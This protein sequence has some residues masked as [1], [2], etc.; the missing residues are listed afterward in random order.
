MSERATEI[1][2]AR[3]NNL[4]NI[5]CRFPHGRLT[6]ITGVSG[7]GKSSLAFDTLYAE[8]QRRFIESMSTYARQFLEK[9]R[10]PDVDSIRNIQPAIAIE[11]KNAVKNAR[12][13]VGSATEILDYLR[14]L[15]A[16]IG[17]TICPDCRVPVERDTTDRVAGALLGAGEGARF[18]LLAPV[19]I[20]KASSFGPIVREMQAGGFSRVWT[21]DGLKG[22]EE[23]SAS[24]RD[25]AGAL[26]IVI[27]RLAVREEERARLA[28]S[29]DLAFQIG[30]G[31]AAAIGA[32]G[33]WRRFHRGF[34]CSTCERT[35]REPEPQL[36]S[37]QSPLGAC[38]HCQGYG[39]VIGVDWDKVIP[40]RA[41]SIAER[42]IAAW[43]TPSNEIL[44]DHLEKTTSRSELPRKTPIQD[45]SPGEYRVL[46][47]GNGEFCGIQG[48]FDWLES[49]KYKIQNR[50][51][52]SKYRGY[53]ECP[54]CGG[55]RLR[56]EALWVQVEGRTIDQLARM[57]IE[58]LG[59]C[60]DEMRLSGERE[61]AV[62]RVVQ[63]L[64]S[65]L[66]YLNGVGL[67]YLT[68]ARQTRTLSG[69]EAQRINLAT[70]L[71]G[72]LT[73]T[74]YVLDEPTVGLHPRDTDRLM[75]VV[76]ALRD[77]GNTVV[78]VEHDPDV[79][80]RADRILDLGPEAGERGGEVIFDGAPGDLMRRPDLSPTAQ[81][82]A[83]GARRIA[84]P[85]R[86]R[87]PS[88]WI[89]IK[90][91]REHNLKN[92][93]ARIPLGVI[94][95]VT[96]V[97]GSG[98][99]TL[100]RDILC[101][102]FRRE[103]EMASVDV[104]A[105][106]SIT[107]LDSIAE[108]VAVDQ[109]LLGRSARSN[110]VTYIKAYD[111]IRELL[112]RQRE[113]RRA[114][115]AA[116]DFSFNVEGGRCERCQGT[117]VEIV[118][119]HFL[120][121]VEVVCSECDGKR[122]QRKALAIEYRGKNIDAILGLTVDEAA[123]F[124]AD[125]PKV[126]RALAPLV[127]VGLGYIRL[128]QSTST[129]SGGEAQRLKLASFLGGAGAGRGRVFFFDEPTRGLHAADL[130]KLL[131]VIHRLV[132]GG[133]TALVIEHNLDLIGHADWIID[134][135]PDGGS[136]GGEIVAEGPLATAMASKRSITAEWL[137]KRYIAANQ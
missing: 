106:D 48:F 104:G 132:D 135:G 24:D 1:R 137:R 23:A 119:M 95:C 38:E 42:A 17:Q 35:F 116:R 40:N 54:A 21:R 51:Y 57:S 71:G 4:K 31:R 3:T 49:K 97:S 126:A 36:F 118:D 78:V 86:G 62:E 122:F 59:A 45:L 133:A 81:R 60:F 39:R 32:D 124:F 121:D 46:I 29:L 16:K 30:R 92:L 120:A 13:T 80:A 74:L 8:G 136:R 114:G 93:D 84:P 129:L 18:T 22:L 73:Q 113:A 47:Q 5:D 19:E 66:R 100:I 64:R 55:S 11:Q 50:V 94:C 9:M 98:K 41:L 105:H 53:T 102:G 109:D 2:G 89:E 88:G 110:P 10:R 103:R 63:E 75:N 25:G 82:Q 125:E 131:G 111:R 79:I 69:G 68:L 130:E 123:A 14:L 112:A 65:R 34:V 20:P 107:G 108:F 43:N 70:A 99:T 134:L 33:Q 101:A 52:L 91:A 117:G 90:G 56:P 61:R 128:G 27:D 6:V 67:G 76:E 85:S 26:W 15:F 28:G 96:G 12:S 83:A 127:E 77:C 44:Y 87:T 37:F 115:V 58:D 72:A 7:S